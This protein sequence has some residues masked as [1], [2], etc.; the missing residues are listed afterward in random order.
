MIIVNNDYAEINSSEI[1]NHFEF[2]RKMNT[3]FSAGT[4][5]KK[6]WAQ[7]KSKLR[8]SFE[9]VDDTLLET[10]KGELFSFFNSKTI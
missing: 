7:S 4:L 10:I 2:T 8:V 5:K 6:A 9:A 1:S 3:Y